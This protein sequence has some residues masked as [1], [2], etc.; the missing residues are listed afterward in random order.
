[1]TILYLHIKLE[2]CNRAKQ[3]N[4]TQLLIMEAEWVSA[5]ESCD[6]ETRI[7]LL[8]QKRIM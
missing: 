7:I 4:R 6:G 8:P 3:Q 5:W 2:A 1:M